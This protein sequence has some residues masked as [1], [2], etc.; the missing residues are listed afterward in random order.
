MKCFFLEIITTC[1]NP[2]PS[3]PPSTLFMRRCQFSY[4]AFGSCG[5][6]QIAYIV[7]FGMWSIGP[8]KPHPHPQGFTYPLHRQ[9]GMTRHVPLLHVVSWPYLAS[10]THSR[11]VITN[12]NAFK[13]HRLLPSSFIRYY[14]NQISTIFSKVFLV[15]YPHSL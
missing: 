6:S 12:I 4:K 7:T 15:K 2:F 5:V 14:N 13:I 8:T 10:P 3:R 1:S 9:Q 11:R